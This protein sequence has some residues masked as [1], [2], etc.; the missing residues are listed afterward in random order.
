LDEVAPPTEAETHLR[1]LRWVVRLAQDRYYAK[2]LRG[3]KT[4]EQ[5]VDLFGEY[6][7]EGSS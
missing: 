1:S 3:S 6:D 4:V 2:V 7:D 5:I